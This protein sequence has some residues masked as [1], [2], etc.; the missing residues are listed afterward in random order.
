[1]CLM[2]QYFGMAVP[3]VS[4]SVVIKA[5]GSSCEWQSFNSLKEGAYSGGR[6]AEKR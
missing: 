5:S 4:H 6:N 3:F 2:V 1:M